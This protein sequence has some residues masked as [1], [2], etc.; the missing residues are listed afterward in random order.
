MSSKLQRGKCQH[1]GAPRTSGATPQ[2]WRVG[3]TGIENNLIG[4]FSFGNF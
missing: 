4:P 3:G 2:F 1:D